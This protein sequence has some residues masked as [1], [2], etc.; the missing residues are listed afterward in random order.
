MQ[1]GH[2]GFVVDLFFLPFAKEVRG[3]IDQFLL[4]PGNFRSK[5]NLS[6]VFFKSSATGLVP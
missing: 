3:V 6:M 2:L 4:P 5:F 1:P